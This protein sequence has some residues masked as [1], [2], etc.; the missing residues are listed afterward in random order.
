MALI[1]GPSAGLTQEV[2]M[3]MQDT[4]VSAMIR[5]H[6]FA[7]CRVACRTMSLVQCILVMTVW[8]RRIYRNGC[9]VGSAS[10]AAVT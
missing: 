6:L 1:A 8:I 5:H 10:A 2:C 7:S 4:A 9:G 3:V